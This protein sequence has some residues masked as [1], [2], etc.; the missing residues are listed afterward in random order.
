MKIQ[1]TQEDIDKG[2]RNNRYDCPIAWAT[3]RT[4]KSNYVSVESKFV[5]LDWG[6]YLLPESAREFVRLFDQGESMR[7][8]EFD[9]ACEIPSQGIRRVS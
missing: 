4:T 8:F 9:L 5:V 3:L 2:C 1:V 6:T 7:P